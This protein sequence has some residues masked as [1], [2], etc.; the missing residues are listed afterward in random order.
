MARVQTSLALALRQ[1]GA[2]QR[3]VPHYQTA[4]ATLEHLDDLE[5]LYQS[6][7]GLATAYAELG[8]WSQARV[9]F[10][11]ALALAQRIGS[12]RLINDAMSAAGWV[13]WRGGVQTSRCRCC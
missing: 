6:T 8:R 2:N 5:G 10:D 12:P 3:A 4:I 9:Q 11:A 7:N 1:H 13:A